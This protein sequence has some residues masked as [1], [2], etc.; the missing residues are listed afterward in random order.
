MRISTL[1][2]KPLILA[3]LVFL[4]IGCQQTPLLDRIISRGEL[5]VASR[6]SPT[7]LYMGA[8]GPEGVEYEL[9]TRFAKKHNL[10]VKWVFPNSMNDFLSEIKTG[11]IHMIAA[12]LS[13]SQK[14]QKSVRYAHPYQQ[15]EDL[16]VY[17]ANSKRP[18]SFN[19]IKDNQL[20][21]VAHSEQE[22][23]LIALKTSTYPHLKW[24]SSQKDG[25]SLLQDLDH[26]LINYVLI[27][28]NEFSLQRKYHRYLKPAFNVGEPTSLSWIFARTA[29]TSVIDAANSFISEQQASGELKLLLSNYYDH[30]DNLNF[31]DKRDFW[32]H[33][34]D[35]LPKLID[36][37]F[38]ASEQVELDWRLLAAIGYQESHWS[39]KAVSP[40]GVRG[41]MMLTRA[42]AKQMNIK[43]RTDPQQSIEG[44]ARYLRKIEGM[45]P[46]RIQEPDRLWFT[47]AGYNVGFG[48]VE[49]A[50]ILTERQGGNPDVWADVKQRLPLLSQKKYYQTLKHGYARGKE[51]V[52]YVENIRNYFDLLVWYSNQQ[53]QSLKEPQKKL[54]SANY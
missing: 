3:S 15:V 50:R 45:I 25:Q 13:L 41:I 49:D 7:T 54:I 19:D 22:E 47:L 40:T 18:K 6:N 37:F 29:D 53:L 26:G 33:V 16:V 8:D 28:K 52:T 39:P 10:T 36:F 20:Y 12:G 31:V 51:P 43:D 48:H 21:V 42:T 24:I 17:R 30:T 11:Q 27:D 35:R 4:L 14:N 5:I 46:K 9:V 23:K 38:Q 32:R 1:H 34:R 2:A 44:G